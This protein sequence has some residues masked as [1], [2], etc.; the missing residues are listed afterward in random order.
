MSRSRDPD[1][2][3]EAMSKEQ[4]MVSPDGDSELLTGTEVDGMLFEQLSPCNAEWARIAFD[5]PQLTPLTSS[6]SP[7]GWGPCPSSQFLPQRVASNSPGQGNAPTQTQCMHIHTCMPAHAQMHRHTC[8]HLHTIVVRPDGGGSS[9]GEAPSKSK[10]SDDRWMDVQN[11]SEEVELLREEHGDGNEDGACWK[12]DTRS[13]ALHQEENVRQRRDRRERV[14]GEEGVVVQ[15]TKAIDEPS[16]GVHD[17][18]GCEREGMGQKE[19]NMEFE[20]DFA[21]GDESGADEQSKYGEINPPGQFGKKRSTGNREA[22][23][24][25]R[26]KQKLEK[27]KLEHEVAQLKAATTQLRLANFHLQGRVNKMET[28]EQENRRLRTLLSEIGSR[29]SNELFSSSV[30]SPPPPSAEA[31]NHSEIGEGSFRNLHDCPECTDVPQTLFQP[32]SSM[33]KGNVGA[34]GQRRRS[35]NPS[36][37]ARSKERCSFFNRAV[38]MGRPEAETADGNRTRSQAVCRTDGSISDRQPQADVVNSTPPPPLGSGVLGGGGPAF[39]PSCQPGCMIPNWQAGPSTLHLP[40]HAHHR[41][42]QQQHHQQHHHHHS[43][44]IPNIGPYPLLESY[45]SS[46]HKVSGPSLPAT[47]A[48]NATPAVMVNGYSGTGLIEPM[49]CSIHPQA[50]Q[51]QDLSGSQILTAPLQDCGENVAVDGQH[52]LEKQR[53]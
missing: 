20:G 43:Q 15:T 27:S 14:G 18:G 44:S 31:A 6:C 1:K 35:K 25:Y 38:A 32:Q 8:Q 50:N 42:H 45:P 12:T 48:V 11:E 17:Q 41:N 26:A 7:S 52:Y 5:G 28:L 29:I 22:V 34:G 51:N 9:A 2:D 49:F 4:E 13:S 39:F 30:P 46:T 24:K 47:A 37:S 16:P 19:N 23:R 33:E 3:C 40:I 36:E 53:A 21:G 10:V